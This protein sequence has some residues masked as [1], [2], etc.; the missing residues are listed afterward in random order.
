[1]WTLTRRKFMRVAAGGLLGAAFDARA[2]TKR[3]RLAFVSHAPDTDS[4][5]TPIRNAIR[6][7][8][9]DFDVDVDYLNPKDGSLQGMA[10][11]LNAIAPAR[12]DGVISTLASYSVLSPALLRISRS[13]HL[14]LITVNSGTI[15]ES[16]LVG[17]LAHV[18]QPEELAGRLAGQL[19]RKRGITQFVCLNHYSSN[20]ASH[21]RCNGFAAGLGLAP[22]SA[23]ELGLSGSRDQMFNV[24]RD[25]LGTHPQT[26]ALLALGPT[27]A[28]PAL[29]AMQSL[30]LKKQHPEFFTFD[31]SPEIVSGIRSGTIEFAI[32]QQPYAQGYLTVALMSEY[33]REGRPAK[34]ELITYTVLAQSKL[35]A[36][37]AKYGI[38]LRP[39]SVLNINSGPGFVTSLNVGL[40]ERFSGQYR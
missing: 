17:A 32:D 3:P 25:Y 29:A 18:G 10:E 20:A 13:L 5:W 33:L 40:V 11:I 35:H 15:E 26:Q 39:S 9:D 7:A 36:R 2:L 16:K 14:P 22:G 34:F 24:V 1:M 12:Y 28:V 23:V 31:I 27:S 8:S 38:E 4:W 6:Q 37:M 21:L 30:K 19:A